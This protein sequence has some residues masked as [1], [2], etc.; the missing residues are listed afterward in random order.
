MYILQ[1]L[2]IVILQIIIKV[3][4]KQ[5]QLKIHFHNILKSCIQV[6]ETDNEQTVLCSV[7]ILKDLIGSFK[8]KYDG[9][10]KAEVYIY[11]IVVSLLC[12]IY[13]R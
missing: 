11:Y 12:I 13:F 7:S 8:P 6:V 5:E 2:R 4:P 9:V 1:E 3:L 10:L